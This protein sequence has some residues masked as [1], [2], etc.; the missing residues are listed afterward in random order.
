MFI[1]FLWFRKLG[2]AQSTLQ[3]IKVVEKAGGYYYNDTAKIY[4][5]NRFIYWY[6]ATSPFCF[7]QQ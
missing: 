3:D 1:R 2:A 4:N 5:R 7:Y 6:I